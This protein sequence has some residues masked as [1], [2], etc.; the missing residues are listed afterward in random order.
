MLL[1]LARKHV[2]LLLTWIRFDRWQACC[3]QVTKNRG[4]FYCN[5]TLTHYKILMIIA[6]SDYECLYANARLNGRVNNGGVWNKSKLLQAIKAESI[7][8]PV[9]Y[10]LYKSQANPVAKL[11]FSA[12]ITICFSWWQRMCT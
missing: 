9:T 6:G 11:D 5:Y 8:L 1:L 12:N 4:Y 3:S 7:K 2:L 10:K